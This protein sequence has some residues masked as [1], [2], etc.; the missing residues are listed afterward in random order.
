MSV[1]IDTTFM[2]LAIEEAR[3]A[4]QKGDVPVGAVIVCNGEIVARAHNTKEANNHA[5]GHAEI[6]AIN[7]ACQRLN[8]WRLT[9]CTLYVTLEPCPMCT[10]A[11]LSARIPRV[12]VGAKDAVAG[13]MESVWALQKNP[14]AM[15]TCDVAF[16]CM[17]SDCRS[18]LQDFF[19]KRRTESE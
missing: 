3:L 10:G 7:Q 1:S 14:G 19:K 2:G 17:E 18:L 13:A 6:N 16:G 4:A 5:T 8:R 11:I 15:G 9:D 12:V